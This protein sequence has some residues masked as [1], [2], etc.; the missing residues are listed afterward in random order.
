MLALDDPDLRAF[1]A[2]TAASTYSLGKE[3]VSLVKKGG[4]PETTHA[5]AGRLYLSRSGWLL[6]SVPNALVRGAFDALDEPG[7]E[8]PSGHNGGRLNSHI[9]VIS[10]REMEKANLDPEAVSERGHSFHY[11]L[12]P[13]R[14]VRP[15]NWEEI[16]RVWYIQVKSPE[17]EKLRLSYGLSARPNNDKFDLHCTIAVR[18]R[19]VL[20]SNT[21]VKK[22]AATDRATRGERVFTSMVPRAALAYVRRHGLLG[23]KALMD[24][25]DA[26]AAAA[27]SRGLSTGE[28]RADIQRTLDGWKRGEAG[29]PNVFFHLPPDETQFPDNHPFRKHDLVPVRVRFDELVRDA[30][31]TRVYGMEL[32]P[33]DP[34]RHVTGMERHRYLKPDEVDTFLSK[35]PRDLWANYADPDK[36][37]YYAPN[38]PHASLHTPD[39]TVPARYLDFPDELDEGPRLPTA[40]RGLKSAGASSPVEKAKEL[41]ASWGD[42]APS[43]YLHQTDKKAWLMVGDWHE[44]ESVKKWCEELEKALPGYELQCESEAQP[45]SVKPGKEKDGW[46]R[47]KTAAE[48]LGLRVTRVALGLPHA[49]ACLS[50]CS[51]SPAQEDKPPDIYDKTEALKHPTTA[52]DEPPP[53]ADEDE[54]PA[55]ELFE[56]LED[57]DD[58]VR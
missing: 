32:E 45:V 49:L 25:P 9:S 50:G 36:S 24:R 22:E 44:S 19:G 23:G 40:L 43:I 47:V 16:E 34:A 8:L 21:E 41:L 31:D 11:T 27:S 30:P 15:K 13:I 56:D 48:V 3:A 10:P 33:Y 17:L 38:V 46:L 37:G 54:S 39:G 55:E 18:R 7:L 26:L 29:G 1:I 4:T 35:S 58:A 42:D 2:R 28:L 6:L 20:R 52:A 5:L 51:E 53:P 14:T 57:L 12:G